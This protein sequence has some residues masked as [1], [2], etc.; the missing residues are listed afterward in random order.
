MVVVELGRKLVATVLECTVALVKSVYLT[1]CDGDRMD[2]SATN[3]CAGMLILSGESWLECAVAGS[4][5]LKISKMMARRGLPQ[6]KGGRREVSMLSCAVEKQTFIAL[7]G[8]LGF[9]SGVF[10]NRISVSEVIIYIQV[11]YSRF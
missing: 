5:G 3:S 8:R 10:K 4:E 11:S 2:V 1:R 9:Q 7:Q 6:R